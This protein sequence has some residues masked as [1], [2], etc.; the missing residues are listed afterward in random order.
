VNEHKD[1]AQSISALGLFAM[2]TT[3]CTWTASPLLNKFFTTTLDGWNLNAWRY[4]LAALC[5]SPMILMH[6]RRRTL[7]AGIFK[8]ALLPAAFNSIGQVAFVMAFYFTSPTSVAIALRVQ[9]IAVAVGGAIF[10]AGERRV[11]KDPRF[12][13]GML[14]VVLGVVGF[15]ALDPS[16]GEPPV[17]DPLDPGTTRTDNPVLGALLG[18]CAGMF[19]GFYGLAVRPMMRT[20]GPILSYA[21][22]SAYTALAM[23]ALL[24][25]FSDDPL[26]PVNVLTPKQG[27]ILVASALVALVIGHPCY[28]FAIRTVGVSA[29]AAVLQLQPITVGV[30]SMLFAI[31]AV[32]TPAQWGA[33]VIAIVAA[34]CMLRVQHS[35]AQSDKR[36]RETEASAVDPGA[37]P[38]LVEEDDPEPALR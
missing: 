11:V 35:I 32:A 9:L 27:A 29:T 24:F 36:L 30:A 21:V 2:A 20:S 15:I 31:G 6:L 37:S 8:R 14:F 10:F 22:I 1:H 7:P 28:Y 3:L 18:A 17:V 19:F 34:V 26:Q 16:F 5:W 23:V 25:L 33:G 4:S 38:V 12:L 13:V